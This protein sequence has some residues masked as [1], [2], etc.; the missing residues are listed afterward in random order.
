MASN[1][2]GAPAKYWSLYRREQFA[3]YDGR[4]PA[5][6]PAYV[7]RQ[8]VDVQ[9]QAWQELDLQAF[10]LQPELIDLGLHRRGDLVA[11][12]LGDRLRAEQLLADFLDETE[13][14]HL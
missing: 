12:C 3:D 5:G 6:A 7:T 4:R 10:R 14:A 2:T 1:T 13:H 9:G 8:L 11:R